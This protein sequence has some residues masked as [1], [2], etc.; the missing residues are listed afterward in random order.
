MAGRLLC[1]SPT[2]SWPIPIGQRLPPTRWQS[3]NQLVYHLVRFGLS[4]SLSGCLFNCCVWVCMMSKYTRMQIRE[5]SWESTWPTG[6]QP[7]LQLVRIC[8][9]ASVRKGLRV[10]VS[11]VIE[12]ASIREMKCKVIESIEMKI[13]LNAYSHTFIHTRLYICQRTDLNIF[14][15]TLRAAIAFTHINSILIKQR[16]AY[17]VPWKEKAIVWL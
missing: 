3:L 12:I 5:S 14:V 16:H 11:I 17:W 10:C 7:E 6:N 15:R 2:E 8:P 9:W 4:V 13:K 1:Q